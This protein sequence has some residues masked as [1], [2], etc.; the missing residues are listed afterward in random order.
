MSFDPSVDYYAILGVLP[1]ADEV[2]IRAAYRALAQRYHPDKCP[3]D[4]AQATERLTEINGAYSVLS[5]PETR[6]GYD[7]AR[8]TSRET[9]SH[10][11]DGPGD[12]AEPSYDP[13]ESK[14]KTAVTFYPDLQTIYSQLRGISWRLGYS[15]KAILLDSKK[16][17]ER[18]ELARALELEFLKSYFGTNPEIVAFARQLIEKRNKA[19]A[20]ALNEAINVL[21]SNVDA[22]RVIYQ[23]QKTFSI[24]K[25]EKEEEFLRIVKTRRAWGYDDSAI[26]SMLLNMGLTAAQAEKT[27]FRAQ[28]GDS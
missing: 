3:N 5:D 28:R 2:V 18:E 21:G 26:M 16:F 8:T 15:F 19:A 7:A 23:L 17:E 14:W 11:F 25:V 20:R 10:Y 13:L 12:D 6:A 22:K 1:S 9:G 4:Q 27:L 24:D